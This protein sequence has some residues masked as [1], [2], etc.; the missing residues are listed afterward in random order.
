MGR[1]RRVPRV[2]WLCVLGCRQEVARLVARGL[3]NRE[4]ASHL[5]LSEHTVATHV[6]NV[7]KKLGLNSRNQI[8]AYFTERH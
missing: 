4:I 7:L 1:G 2:G 5:T 3:S 6:R 8:A